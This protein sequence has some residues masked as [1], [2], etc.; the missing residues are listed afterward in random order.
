MSVPLVRRLIK[1]PFL[2]SGSPPLVWVRTSNRRL[3]PTWAHGSISYVTA[4]PV[5]QKLG[6]N[7][8]STS[9]RLGYYPSIPTFYNFPF[10][11]PQRCCCTLCSNLRFSDTRKSALTAQFSTQ[12][13][14]VS[15]Q[16]RDSAHLRLGHGL[17]REAACKAGPDCSI[18]SKQQPKKIRQPRFTRKR[19]LLAPNP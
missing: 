7:F 14:M 5:G 12:D 3:V 11:P 10:S 16:V 18:S 8:N 19:V 1:I 9:A 2:G 6:A 13:M 15:L 4:A 17:R